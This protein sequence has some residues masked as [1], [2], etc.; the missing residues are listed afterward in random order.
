M[1]AYEQHLNM[2]HGNLHQSSMSISPITPDM[3]KCSLRKFI[4]QIMK[5]H[6]DL[7]FALILF[8]LAVSYYNI[9]EGWSTVD[10]ALF[11]ITTI[12]T[13]GYGNI[14][15]QREVSRL[16]T[17]P[18]IVFG[19]LAIFSAFASAFAASTQFLG[20]FL[21]PKFNEHYQIGAAFLKS[22]LIVIVTIFVGVVVVYFSE[23]VTFVTALYFV[24]FTVTTVGY[25][26]VPIER[27]RT[28]IFLCVYIFFSTFFVAVAFND[29]LLLRRRWIVKQRRNDLLFERIRL[30]NIMIDF[31][32]IFRRDKRRNHKHTHKLHNACMPCNVFATRRSPIVYWRRNSTRP[33][34]MQRSSGPEHPSTGGQNHAIERCESNRSNGISS[35]ET[36]GAERTEAVQTEADLEEHRPELN[37]SCDD[38]ESD[39]A[40]EDSCRTD[41]W[42]ELSQG[43]ARIPLRRA[44]D[45]SMEVNASHSSRLDDSQCS[46]TPHVQQRHD[47][48][49]INADVV[50]P[51]INVNLG[52]EESP[53]V[54]RERH[55]GNISK[56]EFIM[57]I[58]IYLGKVNCDEDILR[59]ARVSM[60][61]LIVTN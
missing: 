3:T 47:G 54:G 1:N 52:L 21:F 11:V 18:V 22:V 17:I 53:R 37:D 28:K 35:E 39:G 27:R 38:N 5:Q 45:S 14:T 9:I 31:D 23:D 7:L 24:V 12:T 60:I 26:D 32:T 55:N 46:N 4:V 34:H 43:I 33:P 36:K 58:L 2:S 61:T 41:W 50:L 15:P 8:S 6:T 49:D 25:G 51:H 40:D 42:E 19:I 30:E 10:S 56:F 13:V 57:S 16:I 59:W 48:H 29:F 44:S 20:K